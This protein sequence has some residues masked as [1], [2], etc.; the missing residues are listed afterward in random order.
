MSSPITA[1]DAREGVRVGRER[2]DNGFF[3]ARRERATPGERDYLSAMALDGDG[4]SSTGEVAMRLGK[5][6]TALGP[7]RAKLIA[8]GLIYPPE[9]GLIAFTVPG[10]AAFIRRETEQR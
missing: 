10:M 5:K 7:I 1:D 9:H 6:P 3:R 2:L 8:K 4:P